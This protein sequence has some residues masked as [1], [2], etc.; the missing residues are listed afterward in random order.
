MTLMFTKSRTIGPN[1]EEPRTR[2]SLAVALAWAVH[3]FTATGAVLALLALTAVIDGQWRL[4]LLWL[5]LALA[6]DGVDGTL[7]RLA[8]VTERVP[9]IDGSA[10][11]LIIDY[12]N[13][14]FI[15]SLLI[16][17]AQLVPDWSAFWLAA[18]IQISSLYV[19]A[20]RDMKS[21]DNYFRGFPALWN[22][23][24]FYL[25]MLEPAPAIGALIVAL[26]ALM[27][28]APV[29]FIHPFRV[30]DYGRWPPI[31]AMLWA[32]STA[33]LLL[34]SSS[35]LHATALPVSLGASAVLVALGLWRSIRGPAARPRL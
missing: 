22:I 32:I 3:V 7:A 16:W 9:R 5:L 13:Y 10:L 18:A 1:M 6:V 24:A 28:F 31:L 34:P 29:H 27:T 8:R 20:R 21:E 12:L 25:L 2:R 4:A 23:V 35:R 33:A 14:V 11:D 17:R 19:F 30:L 15:P 26:L